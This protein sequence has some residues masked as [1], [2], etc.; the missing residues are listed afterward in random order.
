VT[1]A[2]A[3]PTLNALLLA[4]AGPPLGEPWDPWYHGARLVLADW[5]DD[6]D[7]PG[8]RLAASLVRQARA[9]AREEF[10]LPGAP[11]WQS[12]T[13]SLERRGGGP[14]PLRM[15]L[16]DRFPGDDGWSRLS[17]ELMILRREVRM[18]LPP[19]AGGAVAAGPLRVGA[20]IEDES[21]VCVTLTFLWPHVS[22]RREAVLTHH[23]ARG[24]CRRGVLSLF[25][26]TRV[27]LPVR[28][29]HPR[30]TVPAARLV[31]AE[32]APDPAAAVDL[33]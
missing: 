1:V 29:G 9:V 3:C 14:L 20:H 18:N 10:T 6:R 4:C 24:N 13:F 28:P 25:A 12:G 22:S 27:S 11:G 16:D 8:D 7:A 15:T 21:A 33:P 17:S 19:F 26:D 23:A 32:V 2:T 31:P 5:L 30:A